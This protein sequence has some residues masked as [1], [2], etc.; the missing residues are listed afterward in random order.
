MNR[1]R[2][3]FSAALLSIALLFCGCESKS[4]SDV[5]DV[6]VIAINEH[7]LT[8][9]FART[10]IER[11]RGLQG[12]ARLAPDTGMLFIFDEEV[13]ELAFWMDKTTIALSL[14]FIDTNGV[15]TQIEKM[16]PMDKTL[17]VSQQPARF[18]I[19]VNQG[20]FEKHDIGPG[21]VVDFRDTIGHGV[22][23]NK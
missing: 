7:E 13:S 19:E 11:Q 18:V 2:V 6:N 21:D 23:N 20:W 4:G 5:S 8:V 22:L 9:E 3:I 14:A 10:P 16:R 15:I 1:R 17:H 12:C